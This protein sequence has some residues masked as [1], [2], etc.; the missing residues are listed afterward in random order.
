MD[1]VKPGDEVDVKVGQSWLRGTCT[2]VHSR[3][4]ISIRVHKTKQIV[5]KRLGSACGVCHASSGCSIQVA[6]YS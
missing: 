1:R 3:S 2:T 5:T 6:D 4:E